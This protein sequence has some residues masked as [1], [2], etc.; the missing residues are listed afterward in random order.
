MLERYDLGARARGP[1][2]RAPR[3]PARSRTA[4]W[5]CSATT[6]TTSTARPRSPGRRSPRRRTCARRPAPRASRRAGTIVK[7]YDDDG[8]PGRAGRDGPHLRRQRDAVR[9]LHGRRRQGRHRRPD[10]L[11]RRRPLRR[12]GPPVRR[13]PRRRHDR[14]GRRERVPAGGRGPARGPREDRRGGGVRRRRRGV[15][16]AAEGRRRH[17]RAASSPRTRSRSTSSPTSPA[18]RSRATSS[19]STSCRATRPA[20]CSS[21]SSRTT[22][23]RRTETVGRV[24]TV[25]GM[26]QRTDIFELGRLGLTSGEGRRLDLHAAVAGF[27]Y[28][29]QRYEVEPAL[30]PGAPRRLAHDRQR[31]GAAAALRGRAAGPVHALPGARATCTFDVD[32]REVSSPGRRRGAPVAL[33]GRRGRARP[34]GVGAR[35]ARARAARAD[36][37]PARLRRPVPECG[38]NL[39][40][41]PDHRHEP[42]PDP[43]WAKLSE[44][45][46][47]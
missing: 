11:R 34:R 36:H 8:K 33:R 32:A 21:A 14:L 42:G 5:T 47:D 9:G 29:G 38:A 45:K 31:L 23:T 22:R 26:P 43:R 7:L 46:F 18:T 24:A 39:N 13:R 20:R 35:R 19:S 41:D 6:S 1:G 3:C 44:L 15:R 4:G 40:E 17:A 28:G 30:V 10:V 27:D 37:V 25:E 2:V 12:A 16:P